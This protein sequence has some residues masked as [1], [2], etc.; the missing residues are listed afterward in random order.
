MQ[1]D[2]RVMVWNK[3]QRRPGRGTPDTAKSG[4]EDLD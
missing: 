4:M 2:E 1:R 3:D